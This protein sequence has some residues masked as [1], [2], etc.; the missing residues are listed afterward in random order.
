LSAGV[1]A[2]DADAAGGLQLLTSWAPARERG[3]G[4]GVPWRAAL[5][6]LIQTR[7][8]RSGLAAG[9]GDGAWAAKLGALAND[10][11]LLEA[12]RRAGAERSVREHLA[13]EGEEAAYGRAVALA[14]EAAAAAGV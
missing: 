6:A 7:A 1:T 9:A 13:G 10:P 11:W 5:G 4:N 8:G 12:W 2:Q 14:A 3:G